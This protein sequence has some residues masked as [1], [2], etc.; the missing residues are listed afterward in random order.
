MW[1]FI[2]IGPG[3][4]G[5]LSTGQPVTPFSGFLLLLGGERSRKSECCLG[6]LSVA[7]IRTGFRIHKHCR[8]IG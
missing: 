1:V 6:S 7:S 8:E 3:D 5:G 4:L 2:F